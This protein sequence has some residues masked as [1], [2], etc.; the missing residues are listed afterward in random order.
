M[1][2]KQV[3]SLFLFLCAAAV[4]GF[5][6]VVWLSIKDVRAIEA[7]IEMKNSRLQQI[8]QQ[9]EV[10][11][12]SLEVYAKEEAE[13]GQYLFSE[14]D[15]PAFLENISKYAQQADVN[16]IDMKTRSFEEVDAVKEMIQERAK[17]QKQQGGQAKQGEDLKQIL[18]LAAMPVTFKV[19]GSFSSFVEFL[20]YLEEFRQLITISSIQITSGSKYP[21]LECSFSLKIYSLKTFEELEYR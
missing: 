8:E 19:E 6:A 11:R 5:S 16:V 1:T 13:F 17:K 14:K 18:T 4:L 9:A 20:S 10:I 2:R 3:Y 15:V 7:D 21:V 12:Q